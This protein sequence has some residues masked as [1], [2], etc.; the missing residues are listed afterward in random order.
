MQK[1]DIGTADNL[2]YEK[3][4]KNEPVCI[5][6]EMPFE[7]PESWEWVRLGSVFAIEMGQSPA[8]NTVSEKSTG[9]EFHQGKMFFGDKYICPTGK[10]TSTP[11]KYAPENSVLLCV[12]APVGKVNIT[13]RMLCISRGLCAVVPLAGMPL[14]FVYYLLTAYENIFVK[15]A[16]GTTFIAITAENV[17]SQ[18]IPLPPLA[19]QIRITEQVEKLIPLINEYTKVAQ[20]IKTLNNRFP[21]ILKKFILQEAVQGK[22]VPQDSSDEPASVLLERIR[23]EKE[24]L[25]Q[26]GKIKRDK[27]E[28]VIYRRDNSYYRKL[29]LKKYSIWSAEFISPLLQTL[30]Q[31]HL[32]RF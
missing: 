17:K 12:R 27:H 3:V 16:T 19:E 4:G 26:E 15:Q 28:S 5:A 8:G 1:K 25:I 11:T 31:T 13:N 6:D 18:L 30:K 23:M 21:D 9:I 29:Y 14:L 22:L 32:I 2:P 24:R 7:I 10:Y 20:N